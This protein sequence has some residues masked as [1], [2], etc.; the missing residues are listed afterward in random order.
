MITEVS[1]L[2][3]EQF[4]EIPPGFRNNII[5]NVAHMICAQQGVCYGRSGLPVT[6]AEKFI[7]PFLTNTKP[8]HII[9]ED[10]IAEIKDLYLRTVPQLQEDYEKKIFSNYIPSPNI[11]KVYGLELKNIEDAIEFILYH[12]GLHSGTI[13]ALKKLITNQS[14]KKSL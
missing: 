5:W 13:I 8:E 7:T 9:C 4:N 12:D 1:G 11:L 2:S 10:Q 14:S 3:V 6:V